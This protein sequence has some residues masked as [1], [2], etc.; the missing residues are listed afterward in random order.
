V[1]DLL[2]QN[3]SLVIEV[4]VLRQKL[5]ET[6]D[7]RMQPSD[8]VL[9]MLS[10]SK[11]VIQ[12]DAE[13]HEI[14]P[15]AEDTSMV[16]EHEDGR[17]LV[18]DAAAEEVQMEEEVSERC[19]IVETAVDGGSEG[20]MDLEDDQL[21]VMTCSLSSATSGFDDNS[22]ASSVVDGEEMPSEETWNFDV[23]EEVCQEPATAQPP[24]Y[25]GENSQPSG[26]TSARQTTITEE[27][28]KQME[29]IWLS[30]MEKL[31][32]RLRQAVEGEQRARDQM[33]LLGEEK[34]R[35]IAALERQLDVLEANDFHLTKTIHS[36]EHL[37]RVFSSHFHS[38]SDTVKHRNL[39]SGN[40]TDTS[41]N[42]V[43]EQDENCTDNQ[44]TIS[45][46][47]V[48]PN[49]KEI[50]IDDV[51]GHPCGDRTCLQC[52]VCQTL[53]GTV[54][55]LHLALAEQ[56]QVDRRVRDLEEGLKDWRPTTSDDRAALE[57]V[58]FEAEYR[59]LEALVKELKQV[60]VVDRSADGCSVIE[61][62]SPSL[63]ESAESE[64]KDRKMASLSI[65]CSLDDGDDDD[66]ETV[67]MAASPRSEM[68]SPALAAL[69]ERNRLLEISEQYLH[70]Q[71]RPLLATVSKISQ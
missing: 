69:N 3:Q 36:L 8:A 45:T 28:I 4:S 34:D 5:A 60:L 65:H 10:S 9:R 20:T 56:S 49:S 26:S 33:A 50:G 54:E 42:V 71:V 15:G 19:L 2:E 51:V 52:H 6:A 39:H 37:E 25:D 62:L 30:R 61:D 63:N 17:V 12:I 70:Q 38:T 46:D 24:S 11:T 44:L 13:N 43:D 40:A 18:V 66:D 58:D 67:S 31:E 14:M 59:E 32:R 57:V 47:Q 68:D 7:P 48:K 16:V 22:C 21:G 1:D 35:R 41:P 64:R 27:Q 55:Q 23:H 53:K 29:K